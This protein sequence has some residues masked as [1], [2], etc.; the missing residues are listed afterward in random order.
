MATIQGTA[1]NDA[2]QNKIRDVDEIGMSN[3]TVF[4]DAN[5]NGVLDTGEISTQ[6]STS[7]NYT[8]SDLLPGLYTVAQVEQIGFQVLRSNSAQIPFTGFAENRQGAVAWNTSP[9]APEPARIGHTYSLPSSPEIT[10]GS[11]YYL[12]SRDYIDPTAEASIQL[13]DNIIGFENLATALA[14][15]GYTPNDITIQFGLTTLGD[16]VQGQDWLLLGDTEI[17][18]YR[19]G[20]ITLQLNGEDLVSGPLE[21]FVLRIDLEDTASN[22]LAPLSGGI[23]NFTPSNASGSSSEASQQVAQALL[24][25]LGGQKLDFQY[26]SLSSPIGGEGLFSIDGRGGALFEAEAGFIHRS[27]ERLFTNGA[28]SVLLTQQND[29][30]DAVNFANFASEPFTLGEPDDYIASHPDLIRSLGYNFNAALQHYINFGQVEGRSIDNF[31]EEQYLAS[32]DDLKAAFGN[33][34]TAATRHYIEYGFAEGRDPLSGFDSAAYIASHQDLINAFGYSP[35]AGEEHY[36]QNG[37]QEGRTITFKAVEYLASHDDLIQSFGYNLDAATEHYI[38]YGSTEGRSRDMF[39]GQAY[40]NLYADL[41]AA[42]G[43]NLNAA[44]QHYIQNGFSEGRIF[45]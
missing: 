16:D 33:D 9:G 26:I 8:F 43:N 15:N 41:K 17:R 5:T 30:I 18:Y 25:D 40:L 38:T 35:E 13:E 12:A 19:G 20:N 37:Y 23:K 22:P 2:N 10:I 21:E 29:T 28:Y 27:S 7:G 36:R 34:L 44:A 3:V 4:L 6:S 32:Y 24:T 1:W 45:G 39:D 42:F 31:P 11:F 14:Q